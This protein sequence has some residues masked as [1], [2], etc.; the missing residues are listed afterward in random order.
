MRVF[1][2]KGIF[3]RSKRTDK[4]EKENIRCDED[5]RQALPYNRK[6]LSCIYMGEVNIEYKKRREMPGVF[7]VM[8]AHTSFALAQLIDS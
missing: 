1:G 8:V 6:G 5:Q 7:F 3:C 2:A 4:H